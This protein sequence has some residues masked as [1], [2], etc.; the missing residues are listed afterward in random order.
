[1]ES[2]KS[3]KRIEAVKKRPKTLMD[4]S[5]I[6]EEEEK[7]RRITARGFMQSREKFGG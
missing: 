4:T 7:K 6:K 2:T 5:T 1:M 3:T